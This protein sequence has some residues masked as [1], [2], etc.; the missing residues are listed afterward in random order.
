MSHFVHDECQGAKCWRKNI[1]KISIKHTLKKKI[2]SHISR[3]DPKHHIPNTCAVSK[4][5]THTLLDFCVPNHYTQPPG[6]RLFR[7]SESCLQSFPLN[8]IYHYLSHRDRSVQLNGVYVREALCWSWGWLSSCIRQSKARL[9]P[10]C[11]VT[12]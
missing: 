5:N 1:Q 4:V 9:G 10:P 12:R 3:T 8:D 2:Y 6:P 7:N 11:V